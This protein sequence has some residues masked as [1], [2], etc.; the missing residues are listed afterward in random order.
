MSLLYQFY[1][2]KSTGAIF[3]INDTICDCRLNMYPEGAAELKRR[4]LGNV[5]AM[6]AHC[7]RVSRAA[8]L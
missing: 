8:D 1:F 2:V 5:A 3:P 4:G 7:E 6:R